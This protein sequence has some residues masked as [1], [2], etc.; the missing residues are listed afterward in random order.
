MGD[1]IQFPKQATGLALDL[2]DAAPYGFTRLVTTAPVWKQIAD[3]MARDYAIDAEST[4]RWEEDACRH[5][6]MTFPGDN[7]FPGIEPA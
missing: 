4:Q 7:D 3:Q 5:M 1:L 2:D 6:G